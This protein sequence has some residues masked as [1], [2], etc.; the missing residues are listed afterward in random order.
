VTCDWE[1][2]EEKSRAGTAG[3]LEGQDLHWLS[4]AGDLVQHIFI[5]YCGNY[6]VLTNILKRKSISGY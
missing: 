4:C 2:D 5:I 3:V 1:P 6:S